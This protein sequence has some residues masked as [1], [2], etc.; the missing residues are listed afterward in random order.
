[1]STIINHKLGMVVGCVTGESNLPISP[2]L[3]AWHNPE[4]TMDLTTSVH[5]K[6]ERLEVVS[7]ACHLSIWCSKIVGNGR[8]HLLGKCMEMQDG[9]NNKLQMV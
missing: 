7:T 9:S 8:G 2:S 4:H 5:L 3:F 6:T 1:M